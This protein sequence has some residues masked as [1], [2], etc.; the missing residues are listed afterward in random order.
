MFGLFSLIFR[1]A[2]DA[3][4]IES[5]DDD[6]RARMRRLLRHGDGIEHLDPGAPEP[7][8][9]HLVEAL[10]S[11][12]QV[13]ASQVRATGLSQDIRSRL[14]GRVRESPFFA[15][16]AAAAELATARPTH[17]ARCSPAASTCSARNSIAAAP[18][19]GMFMPNWSKTACRS[20]WSSR[21]NA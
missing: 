17:R 2:D 4:W 3:A 6:T 19:R 16:A 10:T 8:P 21:S 14:P 13:L 12:I 15:L 20:K 5:L 7:P 9:R 18:L 11:S 1:K